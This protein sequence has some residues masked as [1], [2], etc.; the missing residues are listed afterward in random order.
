MRTTTAEAAHAILNIWTKINWRHHGLGMLQGEINDFERVHIWHPALREE[1]PELGPY[2]WIHDH[3]FDLESTIIYG[4]I[5][6]VSYEVTPCLIGYG[7]QTICHEITHAKAQ[8]EDPQVRV[9][10]AIGGVRVRETGRRTYQA[11]DSYTIPRR[12]WHTTRVFPQPAMTFVTRSNFDERPARILSCKE[13][14]YAGES[15]IVRGKPEIA[16]TVLD[17]AL[18]D[19]AQVAR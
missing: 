12:A 14:I 16:R 2:R 11:G 17:Q 15:G 7:H 13:V 6:D 3:R 19:L 8:P 4:R 10:R 1:R 9:T 5:T 18:V